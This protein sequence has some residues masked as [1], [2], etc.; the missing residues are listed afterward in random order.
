VTTLYLFIND[1]EMYRNEN[2]EFILSKGEMEKSNPLPVVSALCQSFFKYFNDQPQLNCFS[3]HYNPDNEIT[4]DVITNT[5]DTLGLS[6]YMPYNPLPLELKDVHNPLTKELLAIIYFASF[7][8]PGKRRINV[9]L[10]SLL[11]SFGITPNEVEIIQDKRLEEQDFFRAKITDWEFHPLSV[12]SKFKGEIE[13]DVQEELHMQRTIVTNP[14]NLFGLAWSELFFA[15]MYMIPVSV[16][17]FCG[18]TF[19]L[20]GKS[21]KGSFRK[22]NCG[23]ENCQKIARSQ[24]DQL[25]RQLHE[26][27]VRQNDK[28]RKRNSRKNKAIN[29]IKQKKT[30]EIIAKETGASIADIQ[31]WREQYK[32]RRL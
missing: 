26:K 8:A 2:E 4:F 18:T 25:K 28:V 1:L 12:G 14:S 20:V 21:N 17:T 11:F 32:N 13:E 23:K 15:Q 6:C 7:F 9:R 31:E 24:R 27:D 16:C 5:H 29:M 22:N 3:T 10:Q 19:R 30:N